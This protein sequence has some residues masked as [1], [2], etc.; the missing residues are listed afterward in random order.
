MT[1]VPGPTGIPPVGVLPRYARDPFTFLTH[2]REGYG[3]IAAFDLGPNRTY[4]VMTPALIERV[5]VS[6][7]ATFSKPEFQADVLGRLLGNGLL[8]SEGDLWR[9]RRTMASPAFAPAR[10]ATLAPIM[11][12]RARAMVDRWNDGEVRD[13]EWEMTRTTLE[14]IVEAMFGVD[15]P[16]ATAKKTA[17][18]LEPVGS[19]FEPDPVR[20]VIPDW[21]PTPENRSYEQSVRKLEG[22]VDELVRRRKRAGVGTEET[23]LLAL[24]LR[25]KDAGEI[26]EQ[27]IRDELMTML[28]AGH[29]TTALVLT[30]TW[31][32]LSSHPAAEREIHAELEAV[33]GGDEPTAADVRD[34]PTLRNT[35]R[36]SMRLYPPVY[37]MFR[38]ADRDVTLAGYDVDAGSLIMCS[39]WATHRDPRYFDDPETFDPDRWLE[40][41]HPTYAYFP[42]GAGPR[43]CIGKGFTMLEAPIIAAVVAQQF[44][45]RRV[46]DGPISLR[47]SLTAHPSDGMEMRL[48][49]RS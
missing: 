33:L 8:T 24:L 49:R 28:L 22:I 34:L 19:R 1:V 17:H 7:E 39:Q 11:V 29:D 12:D 3:D 38:Q 2:V 45:L 25:A 41:T 6:E 32:L 48:E 31:A 47:G 43:S 9:D 37:A 4:L 13:I 23:D 36:E 14:I 30:Y 42:F 40:P 10:I 26:D 44:R 35:F 27:G 46:D 16:V 18:L 20:A 5:L 21:M 15:L